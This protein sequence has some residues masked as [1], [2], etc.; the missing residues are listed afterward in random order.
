LLSNGF[1]RMQLLPHAGSVVYSLLPRH[2]PGIFT[3]VTL[4]G[5]IGVSF[6]GHRGA[7]RCY[8]SGRVIE[9]DIAP[10]AAFVAASSDLRWLRVVEPGDALEFDLSAPFFDSV[11]TELGAARA[12]E[13]P[14]VN[15][16]EDALIWGVSARFRAA[17]RHGHPLVDVEASSQ[18]RLLAGHVLH[19]Y[20]GVHPDRHAAEALDR[21]RLARVTELIDANLAGSLT[22]ETLAAAANF[23]PFHFARSFRRATGLTPH[24][25]VTARRMERAREL[26]LE[27]ELPTAT[28]AP[29]VG[30]SNLAHFR[31][32]FARWLGMSPAA[33]RRHDRRAARAEPQ[34]P[35]HT[36]MLT[37]RPMDQ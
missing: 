24:A 12:P 10:G 22:I 35:D 19:R 3:S 6:S 2:E 28:I 34:M 17:L 33:L 11:A 21:R 7:V 26:L 14:D 8:E 36:T 37:M 25:Y 32:S 15:G 31:E 23:S 4:R 5:S 16:A 9:S 27:G 20:G 13:L 1:H 29:L 30:Y 18:V